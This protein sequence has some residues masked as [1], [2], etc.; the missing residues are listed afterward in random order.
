MNGKPRSTSPRTMAEYGAQ[1]EIRSE[2]AHLLAAR[3]NAR[4]LAES[5]AR[6]IERL[7]MRTRCVR[8]QTPPGGV[9]AE[10]VRV[11]FERPATGEMIFSHRAVAGSIGTRCRRENRGHCRWRPGRD[12][13]R[14]GAW[15]GGAYPYLAV[16]RGCRSR[17]DRHQ[18]LGHADPGIGEASAINP[19]TR[20]QEW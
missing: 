14:P 8:Q 7:R 1:S 9:V 17:D 18:R 15:S 2:L 6:S 13:S 3:G 5:T 16:G 20:H 11:P 19:C 10:L 4:V 12:S